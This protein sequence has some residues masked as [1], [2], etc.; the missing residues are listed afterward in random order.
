MTIKDV[1][2]ESGYAVSTVSRVLNGH[3]DVSPVTKKRVMEVVERSGFIPNSNAR[4]LKSRKSQNISILIKGTNNLFFSAVLEQL[5][6]DFSHEGYSTQLHF[7][8]EDEDEVATAVKLQRENKP[9]GFLF[10]GANL[11]HKQ[12]AIKAIK[13]PSVIATSVF[14]NSEHGNISCVG[15]DDTIEGKKAA[16][17]LAECGHKNIAVI[18][19]KNDSSPISAQR[20]NGFCHAYRQRFNKSHPETLYEKCSYSLESGYRAMQRLMQKETM[21]SA[22]FCMSDVIAI[23]AVRAIID[24][25]LS[26][27]NDISIL[28]FDGLSIG[29]YSVPRLTSIKQPQ[30]EISQTATRLL[31]SKIEGQKISE[32][33]LLPCEFMLGESVKNINKQQ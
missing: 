14:D 17:Y 27:P 4:Q 11:E 8:D 2:K 10:L 21:P 7:L 18:G 32:I 28:G 3:P 1:A 24:G 13:V 6:S 22:V 16:E 31:V 20:Y 12:K 15:I 19:G 26:V 30:K 29:K 33:V 5:Q 9:L 25:G 23:G